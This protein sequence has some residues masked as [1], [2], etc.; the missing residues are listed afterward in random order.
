MRVCVLLVNSALKGQT[1][2]WGV[3]GYSHHVVV[4]IKL[5]S[6]GSLL[7]II[8]IMHSKANYVLMVNF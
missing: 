1:M 5:R 3:L 4:G 6:S 2:T 7:L 8:E